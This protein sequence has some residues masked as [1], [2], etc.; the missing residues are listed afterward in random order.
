MRAVLGAVVGKVKAYLAGLQDL[1]HERVYVVF[2]EREV[3]S[4]KVDQVPNEFPVL[5]EA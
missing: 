1:G 2:Q 3:Q 5:T 4:E